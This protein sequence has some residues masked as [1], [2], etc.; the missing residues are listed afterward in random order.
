MQTMLLQCQR[1]LSAQFRDWVSTLRSVGLPAFV[2]G[3]AT[4]VLVSHGCHG[5]DEDHE[6]SVFLE[7]HSESSGSNVQFKGTLEHIR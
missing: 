4:F 6:P 2:M 3:V 1:Y 7:A 5:P